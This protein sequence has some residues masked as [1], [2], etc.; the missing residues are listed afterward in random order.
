MKN[1]YLI[2]GLDENAD[3]FDIKSAYRDRCK[4]CH[5]DT[6]TCDGEQFRTIHDAYEV[7]SNPTRRREY[8]RELLRSRNRE[9]IQRDEG[10]DIP[11]RRQRPSSRRE[12]RSTHRSGFFEDDLFSRFSSLFDDFF[13]LTDTYFSQP[14]R[15]QKVNNRPFSN[16]YRDELACQIVLSPDEARKG[17]IYSLS[18]PT[19]PKYTVHIEIP[20]RV[21][22]GEEF[23]FDLENTGLEGLALKVTVLM[24]T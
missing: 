15:S 3:S 7:L 10:E 9:T 1:Y 21:Q 8:D 18:L 6:S 13:S 22:G 16:F 14:F 11:I 19:S 5:P 4:T 17:G 24:E 2:L 20:G 23:Y 12:R